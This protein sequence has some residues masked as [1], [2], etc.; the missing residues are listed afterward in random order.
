MKRCQKLCDT[1]CDTRNMYP[2][3]VKATKRA[4]IQWHPGNGP[5]VEFNGQNGSPVTW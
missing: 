3:L 5:A 4:G 1:L 2:K